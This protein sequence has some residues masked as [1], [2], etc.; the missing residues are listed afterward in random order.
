M[1]PVKCANLTDNHKQTFGVFRLE[2]T[3]NGQIRESS[4]VVGKPAIDEV[5]IIFHRF[6]M[7]R[8]IDEVSVGEKFG[9]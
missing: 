6:Q 4:E 9:F 7:Q 2:N 3:N 5:V 8:R 1:L